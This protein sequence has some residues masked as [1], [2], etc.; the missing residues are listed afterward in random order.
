MSA[1]G[2]SQAVVARRLLQAMQVPKGASSADFGR[3]VAALVLK[4]G[5]AIRLLGQILWHLAREVEK[6]LG[7]Q[8]Q[9][10]GSESS[11]AKVRAAQ[12]S[13]APDFGDRQ[14]FWSW[15]PL[16]EHSVAHALEPGNHGSAAGGLGQSS[17]SS[18]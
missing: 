12:G 7:S 18:R 5:G 6:K 3:V 17:I 1:A 14:A 11:L 10:A 4:G 13:A 2:S 16:A 9:R 8:A 15:G